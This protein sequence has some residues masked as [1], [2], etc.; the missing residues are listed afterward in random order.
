M[1]SKYNSTYCSDKGGCF[2][3]Q[4]FRL[5]LLQGKP[6]S[7]RCAWLR[8]RIAKIEQIVRAC[9]GGAVAV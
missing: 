9:L 1:T 4:P 7:R 5:P 8:W 2:L 6:L 3:A